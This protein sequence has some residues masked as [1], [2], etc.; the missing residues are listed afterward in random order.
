MSGAKGTQEVTRLG[1]G[2]NSPCALGGGE[3][4][5]TPGISQD[6]SLSHQSLII[7]T[8]PHIHW[9]RVGLCFVIRCGLH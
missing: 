6:L 2:T 3:G 1:V 7:S 8:H 9:I 5:C 4:I